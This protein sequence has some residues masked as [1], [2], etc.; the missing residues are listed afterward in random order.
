MPKINIK[1]ELII[2]LTDDTSNVLRY[3]RLLPGNFVYCAGSVHSG[4]GEEIRIKNRV[5]IRWQLLLIASPSLF[6]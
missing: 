2:L 1:S 5:E 3:F 4:L 6:P